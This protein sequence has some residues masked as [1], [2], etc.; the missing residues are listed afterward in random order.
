M[1]QEKECLLYNENFIFYEL[2]GRIKVNIEYILSIP[3]LVVGHSP[4]M[5]D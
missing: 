2:T 4:T 5:A 3:V 1:L